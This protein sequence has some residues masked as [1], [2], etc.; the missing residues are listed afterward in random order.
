MDQSI[1]AGI[2]NIYASEILYRA[3]INPLRTVDSL[4]GRT[5]KIYY[6]CNKVYFKKV[7]K[8]WW[9]NYK[10]SHAT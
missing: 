10:K 9:N 6:R 7:N 4:N 1:I 3:K 8:C 2:G 5:I